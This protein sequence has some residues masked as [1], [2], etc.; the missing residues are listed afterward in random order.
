MGQSVSRLEQ[1]R[2]QIGAGLDI[3]RVVID[4]DADGGH[5]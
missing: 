5:Q 1:G 2:E 4:M 3:D